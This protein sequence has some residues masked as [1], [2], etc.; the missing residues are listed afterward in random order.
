[1]G[2]KFLN[3]LSDSK[4]FEGKINSL[5]EAKKVIIKNNPEWVINCAG[6]TGRPNID[7]CEDN[8]QATFEANVNLPLNI[9][10]ACK[11]VNVKMVH[12]GSG[13]V[14]QG[15]NNGKGFSEEDKPNFAGSFYSITK[16][17]SESMLKDYDV[18]QL[19]LRMPIDSDPGPRNFITKITNYKQV[20][21]EKNSMTIIE[22]LL[23]AAEILMEREKTGIYNITNP[24]PMSHKEILD[25]Y[26]EIVDS[27]FSYEII[28]LDELHKF[29]KAQRSNCI[30]NTKKLEKEIKLPLLKERITEQLTKYSNKLN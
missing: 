29:T 6:S 22:D 13:C 2:N 30:L 16:T 15:N 24:G 12:L 26:K 7:W 17:L 11:E 3:Y 8:K 4:M 28:S 25:L 19:R 27:S 14:Y 23:K 10:K 5:E 18:L 9:A 21:N 20:I 1:M